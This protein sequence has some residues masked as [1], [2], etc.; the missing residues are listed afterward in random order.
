MSIDR[1][2][3]FPDGIQRALAR[4]VSDQCPLLLEIGIED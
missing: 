1:L 3:L 4:V 2:D